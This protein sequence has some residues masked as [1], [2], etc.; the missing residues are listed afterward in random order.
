[1]Q[2]GG[3][4]AARGDAPVRA[5]SEPIA[6]QRGRVVCAH[7]TDEVNPIRIVVRIE[8]AGRSLHDL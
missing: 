7:L 3:A 2:Y 1:L 6:R 8:V 5:S 4:R